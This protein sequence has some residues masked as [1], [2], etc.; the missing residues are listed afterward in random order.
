VRRGNLFWAI[1][2]IIVG[3][4]LLLDN[5]E[6][7]AFDFWTIL[8]PSLLVALGLWILLSRP[9]RVEAVEGEILTIPLQGATRAEVSIRH[10]AGR[11]SVRDGAAVGDLL[12]GSFEGGLSHRTH[13]EG[14]TIRS[15]LRGG[16]DY[17]PLPGPTGSWRDGLNWDVALNSETPTSISCRTGASESSFDLRALKV[18]EFDL[19]CGANEV[20]L[21][22]PEAAGHT[23]VG[24]RGGM[25][26]IRI[27]VPEKVAARISLSTGMSEISIDETRF[28]RNAGVYES[29]DFPNAANQ[30]EIRIRAGMSTVLID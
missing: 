25:G 14:N 21:H 29:P 30:V 1:V 6:L 8:G 18:S 7:L 19:R 9:I 2:L 24:I 16:S 3:T 28:P 11:L 26:T 15:K 4:F 5:L 20:S 13:K 22:L 10:G 27:H 17:L 12:S 23:R